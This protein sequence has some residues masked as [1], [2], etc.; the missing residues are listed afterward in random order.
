MTDR[1]LVAR[2]WV[3]IK[4][5]HSDK[6]I[7][8]RAITAPIRPTRGNRRRLDLRQSGEAGD[9]TSGASDRPISTGFGTWSLEKGRLKVNTPDWEG[10]YIIEEID[11][12]EMILQKQ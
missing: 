5:R 1:N 11:E 10:E 2:E 6:R 8:F 12:E 4:E 9:K 3:E 7:V